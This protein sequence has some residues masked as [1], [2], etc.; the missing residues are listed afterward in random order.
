MFLYICTILKT[1]SGNYLDQMSS[2]MHKRKSSVENQCL[3]ISNSNY[4]DTIMNNTDF[5]RANNASSDH[6]SAISSSSP[7]TSEINAN[8]NNFTF[9]HH[10][11]HH[12][13]HAI[14]DNTI[15]DEDYTDSPQEISSQLTDTA[16]QDESDRSFIC[17]ICNKMCKSRSLMFTHMR[18][19]TGERPFECEVCG[20]RFSLKTNLGQHMYTHT[21]EKNFEC[22][23]CG[24]RFN[25][26]SNLITHMKVHDPVK[27]RKA[28]KDQETI[29]I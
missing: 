20:K 5:Y 11:H 10:H 21:G 9:H 13:Q 12:N 28:H 22:V 23:Q 14:P 4:E 18:K 7:S 3:P 27:S 2:Y 29:F 6:T 1:K 24:K 16:S 8:Y 26:K 19:H 15:E 17:N 25:R